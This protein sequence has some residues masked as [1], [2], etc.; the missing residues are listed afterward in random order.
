MPFRILLFLLTVLMPC[1]FVFSQNPDQKVWQAV[2]SKYVKLT[3]RPDKINDSSAVQ[4][5]LNFVK[6]SGYGGVRRPWSLDLSGNFQFSFWIKSDLPNNNLEFK[7]LDSSGRNVWWKIFRNFEFSDRWQKIVIK[8]SQIQFAWGPIK[9]RSLINCHSAEIIISSINGGQGK[10]EIRDLKFQPLPEPPNPRP[11]LQISVIPFSS[12]SPVQN[13]IDGHPNTSWRCENPANTSIVIDNGYVRE[14]GSLQINWVKNAFVRHYDVFVSAD[15][16]RWEKVFSVRNSNGGKDFI[17]LMH[18]DGRYLKIHFQDHRG[19]EKPA[20]AEIKIYD[21]KQVPDWQAFW[22]VVA[23]QSPEGNFPRY[24]LNQQTYWTIAG[25]PDDEW[26]ILINEEGQIEVD[27]R[28]FSIEPFLFIDDS[29]ITWAQSQCRQSLAEGYLPFPEVSRTFDGLRL[30]I[31]PFVWK[32]GGKA[33]AFVRYTLSNES[34]KLKSGHFY[35]AMRPF[36]VNPPW[37]ELNNP[38]GVARVQ[39]IRISEHG[40]KVNDTYSLLSLEP[41]RECG[42][43]CFNSAEII[44]FLKSGQLP[45]KRQ[46]EDSLSFAS[47]ALGY[48]FSLKANEKKHWWLIIGR[49]LS[50]IKGAI[51]EQKIN[52]LQEEAKHYWRQKLNRTQIRIPGADQK[53]FNIIRANLAYIL[54]NRDGYGFQPGSRSYERSWIR[55]GSLTSSALL[56]FGIVKE[57]RQFI[58]WY[59]SYQDSSGRVP[60]VVDFRGPDPVPEHDSYGQLIFAIAEY[61]R[62]TS[63]TSFL[64]Q[65]WHHVKRAIHYLEWLSAQRRTEKY[66]EGSKV[67]QACYGLLPESISHEGYSANPMHSYWDDFF[68]L[69]GY[70]DAIFIAQVLG[71]KDSLQKWR[72]YE[73]RFVQ[74][75]YRSIQMATHLHHINYIPGCVELGDFDATSTAIAIYPCGEKERLE[76]LPQNLLQNTFDRYFDFFTKRKNGE[77]EW[78]DYTPYEVRLINTFVILNQVKRAEQLLRFFVHDQRPPGWQHWAEIVRR[79]YRT[80]GFIGDMPHTWVGSDFISVVRN[81]FVYEDLNKQALFIGSGLLPAWLDSDAD[82]EI[83][84]MPTVYGNLSYSIKKTK[85]KLVV[86]INGNINHAVGGIWFKNLKPQAWMELRSGD[87]VKKRKGTG[88]PYIKIENLPVTIEFN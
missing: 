44:D 40:A 20:I 34:Q 51:Q 43:T 66:L 32:V 25:A 2:T 39:K 88:A 16:L 75:V 13:M 63:D 17:P 7:L 81:M 5:S 80:P 57:V 61:F 68:A 35:L 67:E 10:V 87:W 36:Q 49:D 59:A 47:A 69:K 70:K 65:H 11:P 31:E 71:Q 18:F 82:I 21:F 38:G 33:T 45:T 9:D 29:L 76:R 37:Q 30:I 72:N 46:V 1:S 24:W 77:I 62:F 74:N 55:D 78:N 64:R 83:N 6:G 19:N 58:D 48:R 4:F 28:Q 50:R 23:S 85:H 26:E 22:M 3:L 52:R 8:K 84:N 42:A 41:A 56:K 14:L 73:Q 60:C 79:A 12:R 86:Q 15:S 27:K 53:L 54:I